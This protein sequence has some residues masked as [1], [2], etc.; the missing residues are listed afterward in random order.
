MP[1]TKVKSQTV[2]VN[3]L[4]PPSLETKEPVADYFKKRNTQSLVLYFAIG[5][6]TG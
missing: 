4:R 6:G 5:F 2:I 1:E 3:S